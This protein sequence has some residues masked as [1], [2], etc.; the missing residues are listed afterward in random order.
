[1]LSA[2]GWVGGAAIRCMLAHMLWFALLVVLLLM[3]LLGLELFSRSFETEQQTHRR[4]PSAYQIDFE[5]IRFPTRG[6][7]RLYGW[8]IPGRPQAPLLILVHGWKRNVERML[9]LV[10][11]LNS[12][13]YSLLLFDAR[14]H[15]SSDADG[16]SNMLK[17]SEDIRA[18]VDEGLQRRGGG[19]LGL[20]GHSVGGAACLHATSLDQRIG[21]VMSIGA[22]AHPGRMMRRDFLA[23]GIPAFLVPLLLKYV[24][25]KIGASLDEIAPVNRLGHISCPIAIIHG[26]EDRIVPIEHGREL[27]AAGGSHLR[28]WF[29]PGRGHSDCAE[30]DG[31]DAFLL[32]FFSCLEMGKQGQSEIS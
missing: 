9:P 23:K 32:D 16:L 2:F 29:I 14:S 13:G 11:L 10:P 5:E 15:G 12:G 8:W 17:F 25:W 3:S 26:E 31:F 1:M 20:I 27:A 21:A 6:G 24:S 18:A 4:D 30:E 22:F 28:S 7:L 19:P